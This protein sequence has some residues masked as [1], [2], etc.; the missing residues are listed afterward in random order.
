VPVDVEMQDGSNHVV[1]AA[2][3]TPHGVAL[4]WM[5]RHYWR[6][7]EDRIEL[8]DGRALER[9]RNEDFDIGS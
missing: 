1:N 3:F 6:H 2:N 7:P 5:M 8:T 4:Y 9:L